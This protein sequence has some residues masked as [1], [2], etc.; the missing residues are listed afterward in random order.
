MDV[1]AESFTQAVRMLL[2]RIEAALAGGRALREPVRMYIAGGCAVHHYTGARFTEDIDAT[3]SRRILLPQDLEVVWQAP[4]GPR[5]L[6]LDTQYNDTFGLLHENSDLDAIE[7]PELLIKPDAALRVF[8]LS[9][10]DLAVSKLGRFDER[11][12]ADI[13]TLARAG[14]IDAQRFRARALEALDYYVGS[15]QR[16]RTSIDIACNAIQAAAP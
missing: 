5:H 6:Y 12:Q 3:F 13:A 10:L 2:A 14:L 15:T 8:F 11:D 9:P 1:P 7:A 4:D 16:V